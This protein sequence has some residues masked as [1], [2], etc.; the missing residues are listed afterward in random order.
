METQRNPKS[1]EIASAQPLEEKLKDNFTAV[2][3]PL[4]VCLLY[5]FLLYGI[6]TYTCNSALGW[7]Y[8]F[9]VDNY[10][11]Q[12]VLYSFLSA[13]LF[14]LTMLTKLSLPRLIYYKIFGKDDF[15]QKVTF[16]LLVCLISSLLWLPP[17]FSFYKD[18]YTHNI[19]ETTLTVEKLTSS[20]WRSTARRDNA[21]FAD[22]KSSFDAKGTYYLLKEGYTYNITYLSSSKIILRVTP[23]K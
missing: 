14:I 8:G 1:E 23:Q 17:Y 9:V 11:D 7:Q 16:H 6:L 2:Q 3:K 4:L 22:T 21:F 10:V 18:V 15:P 12:H 19:C 5:Y 20:K 13:F